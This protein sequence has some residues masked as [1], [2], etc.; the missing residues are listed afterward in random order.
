M[1]HQ[2][3]KEWILL[4]P[5]LDEKEKE[6]LAVH[7]DSCLECQELEQASRQIDLLFE[8][9]P[10]PEPEPGFSQRFMTHLR[11]RETREKVRGLRITFGL[12]G[13]AILLLSVMLG[14]H[15]R[16]QI[17][18]VAEIIVRG[19]SQ[20]AKWAFVLSHLSAFFDT[21]LDIS[22]SFVPRI[23]LINIWIGF[24]IAVI[25][26]FVHLLRIFIPPQEVS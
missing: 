2:L 19:I 8:T 24:I 4:N 14:F 6:K 17:P 9:S 21:F 3:Y 10:I 1:N 11:E 16:A 25:I 13:A 15:L 22:L 18:R 26:P 12:I 23:W 7:L 5:E 20:T